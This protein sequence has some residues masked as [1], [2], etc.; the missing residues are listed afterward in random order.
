[1]AVISNA[2]S[3]Y[4]LVNEEIF[5]LTSRKPKPNI[6]VKQEKNQS[7]SKPFSFSTLVESNANN[8]VQIH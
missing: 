6:C 7:K 2:F 1:M 5:Q 3:A 8:C 4:L